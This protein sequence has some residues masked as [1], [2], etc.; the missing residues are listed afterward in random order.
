[1]LIGTD[2]FNY[3]LSGL[4]RSQDCANSLYL[5]HAIAIGA[6]GKI[7]GEMKVNGFDKDQATLAPC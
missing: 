2:H 7:R 1:M 6:A 5:Q 3:G 4:I